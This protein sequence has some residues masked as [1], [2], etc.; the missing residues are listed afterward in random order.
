MKDEIAAT[1]VFITRLVKKQDKLSKHT[2]EK[3][4]AKL[5]TILFEKYKN[6]WYLDNP[7]KGQAFRCIRINQHQSR[8]PV[9]EQ[10]CAESNVD[11]EKLCLPPEMT[12][13]VDPF[14]V[15]CRYGEK[16][17]PFTI[18]HFEGEEDRELS[19]R[20]SQA[21]DRATPEYPSGASSDEEGYRKEPKAIP[22]V[23][24]P[25]SV[26]QFSDYCKLPMQSWSQYLR[27]KTYVTDSLHLASACFPQHKGYKDYKPMAAF[28]GP[29]VD[30]YHWVNTKR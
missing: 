7:S 1:V 20:I 18:A 25:N 26:Y 29:R 6:H 4:A 11:F 3:F 15:C 16:N 27:R 17:L 9:L 12:I 10:A 21:V 23:S 19:Q 24:N 28:A 8:D 22:M 13:W 30:R 2:T 14:D 5:T